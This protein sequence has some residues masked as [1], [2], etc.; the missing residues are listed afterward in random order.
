MEHALGIWAAILLWLVL[1]Q[2]TT[3]TWTFI[4][5]TDQI[6]L[7]DPMAAEDQM[8]TER[9]LVGEEIAVTDQMEAVTHQMAVV[10]YQMAVVTHQMAVVTHQMAEVGR[11]LSSL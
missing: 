5:A 8:V 11:I 1:Y 10:T 2:S 7:I 4:S 3:R 9:I 6:L